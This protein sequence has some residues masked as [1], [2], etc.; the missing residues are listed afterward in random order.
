MVYQGWHLSQALDL[1]WASLVDT[2]L[3]SIQGSNPLNLTFWDVVSARCLSHPAS[4]QLPR[5]QWCCSAPLPGTVHCLRTPL[6]S[7]GG[8]LRSP[9]GAV[10]RCCML[11]E[12]VVFTSAGCFRGFPGRDGKLVNHCMSLWHMYLQEDVKKKVNLVKGLQN[13]VKCTSSFDFQWYTHYWH[14]SCCGFLSGLDKK[15]QCWLNCDQ[16]QNMDYS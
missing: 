7:Q 9:R 3:Y 1:I 5:G 2:V 8:E 10:W 11:T 16:T 6:H 4:A 15:P 13:S 14:R 12:E